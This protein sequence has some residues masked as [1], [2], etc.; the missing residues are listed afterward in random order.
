[1]MKNTLNIW[2]MKKYCCK[3]ATN[4]KYINININIQVAKYH[5]VVQFWGKKK[6]EEKK[7]RKR[8]KEEK[9]KKKGKN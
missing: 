8:K 6:N 1:M 9:K 2:P 3:Q 5:L 7:K 4:N